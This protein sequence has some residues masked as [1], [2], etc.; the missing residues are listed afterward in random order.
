MF[1]EL[2]YGTERPAICGLI[3][4]CRFGQFAPLRDVLQQICSQTLEASELAEIGKI[5]RYRKDISVLFCSPMLD[6]ASWHAVTELARSTPH[7][8]M[9]IL[10]ATEPDAQV[11]TELL[12]H[13]G[14]TMCSAPWVE[15]TMRA[16]V[17]AAHKR[18]LRTAEIAQAR[19]DNRRSVRMHQNAS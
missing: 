19:A 8:P 5:L 14:F 16:T 11:W 15:D 2:A 6:D 1:S 7:G 12:Q 10:C 17:L 13:G 4:G 9:V 3:A 18:W